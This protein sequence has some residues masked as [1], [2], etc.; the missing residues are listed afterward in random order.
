ML[1]VSHVLIVKEVS[2]GNFRVVLRQNEI[3]HFIILQS[4][5]E[6][7]HYDRVFIVVLRKVMKKRT[8]RP[9]YW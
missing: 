2:L 7:R 5:C 1:K 6:I 3:I 9:S 4:V 8:E